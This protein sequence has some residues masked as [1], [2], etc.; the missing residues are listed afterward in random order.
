MA[1]DR[2]KSWDDA[3]I[4]A[5][6]DGELPAEEAARVE[7]VLREDPAAAEA[8]RLM[9]LGGQAARGAYAEAMTAPLPP[10]LAALARPGASRRARPSFDLARWLGLAGWRGAAVAALAA[11]VAFGL[12]VMIPRNDEPGIV[13]TAGGPAPDTADEAAAAALLQA[14]ETGPDGGTVAAGDRQIRIIGPVDPG[15]PARCRAFR[16]LSPAAED[17]VACRGADGAWAVLTLPAATGGDR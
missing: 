6:L 2:S 13:R 15:F 3:L 9:R 17:G 11:V 5:Y 14:L 10:G 8:A 16:I 4:V 7:A 12:G 1:D